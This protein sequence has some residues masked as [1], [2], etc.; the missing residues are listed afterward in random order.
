MLTDDERG[1]LSL[2]LGK[3]ADEGR[4]TEG[5]VVR[6]FELIFIEFWGGG[7]WLGARHGLSKTIEPLHTGL[8]NTRPCGR[9]ARYFVRH[10]QVDQ[11][12]HTWNDKAPWRGYRPFVCAE[13]CSPIAVDLPGAYL[14]KHGH[15]LVTWWLTGA[16]RATK[17]LSNRGER[18]GS[19][20]HFIVGSTSG[21][22]ERHIIGYNSGFA[23][24]R[25]IL[26]RFVIYTSVLGH[27]RHSACASAYREGDPPGEDI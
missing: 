3:G 10:G 5:E 21:K 15:P 6:D 12:G 14:N 26:S 7:T 8:Y 1:E 17:A 24:K 23:Y 25:R 9:M 4:G 16:H 18:S 27:P 11:N 2:S 22:G 13:T 20:N 19:G